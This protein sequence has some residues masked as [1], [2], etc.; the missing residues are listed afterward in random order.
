VI[1]AIASFFAR[2]RET[3]EPTERRHL[4]QVREFDAAKEEFVSLVSQELR[5]PLTSVRGYLDL[6]LDGSAGELTPEQERFL[7]VASRSCDRLHRLVDDLLVIAHAGAGRLPLSWARIDLAEVVREALDAHRRAAAEKGVELVL[8]RHG[9]SPLLAD[10]MRFRQL[11]D[12]LVTSAVAVAPDG[13]TVELHAHAGR[14]SAQLELVEQ[15]QEASLPGS[16][17]SLNV[18]R[19]IAEAHGGT[20]DLHH[21]DGSTTV[22]VTVPTHMA[23]QAQR[24]EEAA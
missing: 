17:L 20:L 18:V 11:V 3:H 5:T 16:G 7:G 21:G 14:K 1:A 10:R 12:A 2:G 15:T 24:V 13:A 6:V 8:I 4:E 23:E 9:R 22:T 19:A